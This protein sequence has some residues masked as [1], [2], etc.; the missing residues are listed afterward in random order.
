MEDLLWSNYSCPAWEGVKSM[1]G[2]QNKRGTI[3][4]DD[5]SDL[6]ISNELNTFFNRFN[7]YDFST[8]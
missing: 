7:I 4:L 1:M 2:M 5:K 8:E 3:S 6:D